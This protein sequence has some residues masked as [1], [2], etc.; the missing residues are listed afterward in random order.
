M[1]IYVSLYYSE[2][3]LMTKMR[4]FDRLCTLS[5]DNP[6]QPI[7]WNYA[8]LYLRAAHYR[9]RHVSATC[10]NQNCNS[11]SLCVYLPTK[12]VSIRPELPTDNGCLDK[13]RP[14][15]DKIIIRSSTT[16]KCHVAT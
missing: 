4:K 1:L 10:R 9:T 5:Y 2:Y 13:K 15:S 14:D 8:T 16:P 7:G 6:F 12:C 3:S 11:A